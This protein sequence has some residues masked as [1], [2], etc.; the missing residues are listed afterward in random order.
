MN[1]NIKRRL[2]LTMLGLAPLGLVKKSPA[3]TPT[4]IDAA[5][6]SGASTATVPN[7]A[8]GETPAGV[9]NGNNLSFTLAHTPNP[10]ASLMLHRNGVLQAAG[11]DYNL[12]AATVFV[13]AGAVPLAGDTL[14]AWYRY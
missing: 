11:G 10:P 6:I 2:W 8:D 4:K 3:Q 14:R 7:F 9:V 5:Q 1:E 13:V 12:T